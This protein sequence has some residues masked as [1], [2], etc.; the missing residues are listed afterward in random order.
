LIIAT[1][2]LPPRYVSPNL[3]AHGGMGEVYRATDAVLG[4]PVAV[5]LLAERYARDP[6]ARGR[7]KREALAAARL[8]GEPHVITVFDVGEHE[9]RPFIVMEYLEGGSLHDKL[10]AG[11]FGVLE[12]LDW[13]GQAAEALDTAHRHGIVHR[14]VKPANLLLDRGGSLRVSDFGVASAAGLDTL[15][16][17]GTVLGTAGYLA[18]EQARG[19]PATPASDRYALGVVAFELLTGRRPYA[20]DTPLTEAFAHVSAPIPS[21]TAITPALPAAV[22]AVLERAL[23][24]EAADRPG[25]CTELVAG[26]R[27]A[28]ADDAAPTLVDPGPAAPTVAVTAPRHHPRRRRGRRAVAV[29]ALAVGGISAGALVGI[30]SD[31]SASEPAVTGAQ[32]AVSTAQAPPPTTTATTPV[33]ETPTVA[34]EPDPQDGAELNDAGFAQQEAGNYEAALPLLE[35]AVSALAGSGAL[36]E[37][38]ASYNLAFTRL[39]LGSCDGVPALLDRSEAVQGPRM[40]IDR[41]RKE[42]E[43]ACEPAQAGEDGDDGEGNGTP[44]NGKKKGRGHGRD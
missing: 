41:L 17:P 15:T 2:I 18:P 25:S 29:A 37:A 40:E 23:A 21:A 13:L 14:D 11:V 30:A 24:K 26:I 27:N 20:A 8:S 1:Q 44:G 38:W 34:P 31:D 43:Q 16:L 33:A 12:A 35:Q 32:T 5:K 28:F 42:A 3:V 22:D 9:E 7:F 4:R 36:A 10:T 39:S 19:E 6:E